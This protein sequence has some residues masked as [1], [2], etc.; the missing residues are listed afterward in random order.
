MPELLT[1]SD[2]AAVGEA[3]ADAI[4]TRTR[5][6]VGADGKRLARRA[7]GS[8]ST[9][10]DTGRMLDSL[11]VTATDRCVT[12]A[13][14]VAYARHADAARPF[15]GLTPEQQ[16]DTA[17]RALE[18]RLAAREAELNRSWKARR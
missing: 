10:T 8:A 2:L 14:T 7:D 17:D 13:P 3:V 1:R 12:V 5:G 15:V 9:L 6:G 18:G 4:R 16:H 11:L